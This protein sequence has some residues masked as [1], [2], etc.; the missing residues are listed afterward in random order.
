VQEDG[1]TDSLQRRLGRELCREPC[2]DEGQD[3]E[4]LD[5]VLSGDGVLSEDKS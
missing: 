3:V 1:K 2:E 4:K 5:G